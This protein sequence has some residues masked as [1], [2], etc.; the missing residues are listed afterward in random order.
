[1]E[2]LLI[3]TVMLLVFAIA[4]TVIYLLEAIK[5]NETA[6]IIYLSVMVLTML[7]SFITI[8]FLVNAN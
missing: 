1:M 3:I 8:Y 4:Y 7:F 2:T 6:G 5:T